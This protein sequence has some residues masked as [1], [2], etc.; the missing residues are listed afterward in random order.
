MFLLHI[1]YTK[2][3]H[4][5]E[6]GKYIKCV[7][8]LGQCPLDWVPQRCHCLLLWEEGCLEN[9]GGGHQFFLPF[10]NLVNDFSPFSRQYV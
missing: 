8:S 9:K 5:D 2:V 1:S 4:L 3:L 6:R 10:Q 7:S